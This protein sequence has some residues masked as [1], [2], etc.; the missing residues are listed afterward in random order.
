MLNMGGLPHLLREEDVRQTY[1]ELTGVEV[2]D[3]RWFYVFASLQWCVVFMRTG[4]VVCISGRWKH[5][6]RSRNC[7]TIVR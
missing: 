1:R 6:R 4:R 5:R 3:L 7:S 2:G